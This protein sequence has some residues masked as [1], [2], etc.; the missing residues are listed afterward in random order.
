M[1]VSRVTGS[2]GMTLGTRFR[3][4]VRQQAVDTLVVALQILGPLSRVSWRTS[5]E[6]VQRSGLGLSQFV[7]MSLSLTLQQCVQVLKKLSSG[8]GADVVLLR[9]A[10]LWVPTL[11]R[12]VGVELQMLPVASADRTLCARCVRLRLTV[13]LDKAGHFTSVGSRSKTRMRIRMVSAGSL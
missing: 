8:Q 11:P 2:S 12:L 4:K 7:P 3:I 10:S 1:F 5:L 9:I 13:R 6:W